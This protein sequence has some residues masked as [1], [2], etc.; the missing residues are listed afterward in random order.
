MRTIHSIFLI[1]IICYTESLAQTIL[2]LDYFPHHINDIYEYKKGNDIYCLQNKIIKDSLNKDGKYYL[3]INNEDLF[4]FSAKYAS[5]RLSIDTTNHEVHSYYWREY[6]R[7]VL[8]FKL[9]SN[10]GDKWIAINDSP[11]VVMAEV[12][13][14]FDTTYFGENVKV[15][16]IGYSEGFCNST[17]WLASKFGIIKKEEG[18][19][20]WYYWDLKGAKIDGIVYGTIASTEDYSE[21]TMKNYYISQNYPNPFN[22][23]TVIKYSI[24]K[25]GQVEIKV[26]DILGREVI[27]LVNEEKP[28]GNYEVT[29]DGANLS[30]G[31]Y[32]YKITCGSFSKTKKMILIK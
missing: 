21:N 8:W 20:L 11:R 4:S 24:P 1:V 27:Q 10:L 30:C 14:I 5:E 12:V 25:N 7:E 13:S 28:A 22:P 15:K 18:F 17:I 23:T 9:N 16:L 2:P 19:P 29:F 26:F 6:E 32:L 3:L 31:V